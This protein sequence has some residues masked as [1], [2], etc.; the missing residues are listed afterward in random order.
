V[1]T[2]AK[3]FQVKV[4]E[5]AV[6]YLDQQIV[7][8]CCCVTL[9]CLSSVTTAGLIRG[10]WMQPL[11]PTNGCTPRKGRLLRRS[12]RLF[13]VAASTRTDLLRR[14]SMVFNTCFFNLVFNLLKK[15]GVI[16]KPGV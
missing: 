14:S 16:K 3:T 13:T 6:E 15:P 5:K 12:L 1:G 9:R 11:A 2:L 10:L 4:P 7:R 8:F